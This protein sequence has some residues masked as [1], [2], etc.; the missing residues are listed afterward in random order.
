MKIMLGIII[1]LT[2]FYY[3]ALYE[4]RQYRLRQEEKHKCSLMHAQFRDYM[5]YYGTIHE[6]KG[7]DK[8]VNFQ[9]AQI[10]QQIIYQSGC[11]K[12]QEECPVPEDVPISVAG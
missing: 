3:F 2:C 1:V 9:A 12:Y 7:L 10:I 4:D 6:T 11:C 8:I 5:N